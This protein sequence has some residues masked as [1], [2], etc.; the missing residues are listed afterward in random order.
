[1]TRRSNRKD[2]LR[3]PYHINLPQDIRLVVYDHLFHGM[4]C[5]AKPYPFWP[6]TPSLPHRCKELELRMLSILRVSRPTREEALPIFEKN[7]IVSLQ[8]KEQF[9]WIQR[10]CRQAKTL[11][12]AWIPTSRIIGDDL[13][14]RD[15]SA[16]LPAL[17][18]L[19][20]HINW[21]HPITCSNIDALISNLNG[22]RLQEHVSILENEVKQHS[23]RLKDFPCEFFVCM[24]FQLLYEPAGWSGSKTSYYTTLRYDVRKQKI[25]GRRI[26][27]E[28]QEWISVPVHEVL[29]IQKGFQISSA[30]SS[31]IG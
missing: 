8:Y 15:L 4:I 1:M 2:R 14:R 5:P 13:Y 27:M 20:C 3:L 18:Q 7:I 31:I 22:S 9:M 12:T 25:V 29:N 6:Q 11:R 23:I 24:I 30:L 19:E 16:K 21:R 17:K 26:R 28:E 10:A